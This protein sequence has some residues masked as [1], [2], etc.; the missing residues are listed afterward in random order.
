MFNLIKNS[1]FTFTTDRQI[2][3]YDKKIGIIYKL[4]QIGLFS[5]IL[6]DLFH[7]QLYFKTEIPSGYTTMWAE[8][9]DL[10]KIQTN[11]T[12]NKPDYCDN[13]DHNYIYSLPYWD[14]RNNSCINLHYSE[15]YQK[16]ENEIFFQ[17]YFTENKIIIK[18]C[19]LFNNTNDE[20][21]IMDRLDGNC[22]CQNYKNFYSVG[23]DGMQL[24]F[25]HLY[26]TSFESGSNI[27][28]NTD[29]KPIKT[30]INDVDGNK[31]LEF[32]KGEN[33]VISIDQWFKLA[34]ISIDDFNMGVKRSEMGEFI[35][36]D[37]PYPRYRMSGLEFIL[38]V[39]FYNIKTYSNFD[40]TVCII[41]TVVNKGWASKGS[42]INYITYPDLLEGD[43]NVQNIYVDRYRY[44][45]KF[46]FMVSGLM[47]KFDWYM[48]INHLVS[49]IVLT[50]VARTGM[51][52][53][54]MYILGKKSLL[55]K[56]YRVK[57]INSNSTNLID[58]KKTSKILQDNIWDNADK[59]SDTYSYDY[60]YTYHKTS[61]DEFEIENQVNSQNNK[62]PPSNFN[63]DFVK[64][65]N[66][67]SSVI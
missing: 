31:Q 28:S 58:R 22:F 64:L 4:V 14:Y 36:E 46:K 1:F 38:K 25:N 37:L 6:F 29:V 10:Y 53:I 65:K 50:G 9:N 12:I 35:N 45:I 8:A 5:F 41:D 33:I 42:K 27:D 20:C 61:D 7:K 60:D 66:D 23:V 2:A 39:N 16:G 43:E 44:G 47:G 67:F 57:Q 18:N 32:D 24:V 49:V 34:K 19:E 52:Y 48:L 15:M 30:I 59:Y 26:T 17:T 21:Q 11:A 56:K 51:S 55:F 40:N 54:V 63:K 62:Q 13:P 3:F